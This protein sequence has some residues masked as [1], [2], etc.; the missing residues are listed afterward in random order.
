MQFPFDR[1]ALY[2]VSGVE[3]QHAHPHAVAHCEG[4]FF[5]EINALRRAFFFAL[6]GGKIMVDV[7]RQ[8]SDLRVICLFFLRSGIIFA[9]GALQAGDY[10]LDLKGLTDKYIT[11]MNASLNRHKY[12][13]WTNVT[14]IDANE[15]LAQSGNTQTPAETKKAR[16]M[17]D[18]VQVFMTD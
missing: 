11:N 15:T 9:H 8:P 17:P 6:Q 5:A 7:V 4:A 2:R 12:V 14:V 16:P 10:V 1:L 18:V 3:A 13:G